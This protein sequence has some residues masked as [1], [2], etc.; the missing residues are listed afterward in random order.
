MHTLPI[1]PTVKHPLTGQPIRAL[2]FTKRNTPIWPVLGGS[3]PAGGDPAPA[4]APLT[5]PGLVTASGHT[6]A[7]PPAVAQPGGIAGLMTAG[8]LPVPNFAPATQPGPALPQAGATWNPTTATQPVFAP[9]PTAP[10]VPAPPAVTITGPHV[11]PGL[12][13]GLPTTLPSLPA[14]AVPAPATA[15]AAAPAAP[16]PATAPATTEIG[17]GLD[18]GAGRDYPQGKPLTEMTPDEQASYYKWY[19][20]Q[21]ENRAKSRADY[22]AVKAKADQYDQLAAT[23]TTDI[24]RQVAAAK[25]AGYAEAAGAAAVVLVDAHLRAGLGTRLQP[26]QV[27]AL[28]ANLNYTHFLTAD[29]RTVD[30]AKV[31][32]YVDAVAPIAAVQPATSAVPAATAP[33]VPAAPGA[34]PVGLPIPGQPGQPVTGLPRPVPDL[35]QGNQ[36]AAPADKLALGRMQAEQFLSGA[37]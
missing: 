35:G 34:L 9:Q 20:R 30:A 11:I 13:A 33:A 22:D 14:P 24:E 1:H 25:A 4:P 36:P 17:N 19:S 26:H 18:D 37:F 8:T 6:V 12:P 5:I 7:A 28:A 31:S 21:W 16:T 2:G 29:G 3:Q 15:P 27:E 10:A 23:Q 32:A